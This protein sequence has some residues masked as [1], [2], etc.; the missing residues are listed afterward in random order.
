[1]KT[2]IL[3]AILVSVTALP[4]LAYC[5]PLKEC[6]ICGKT[7]ICKTSEFLGEEIAICG[8]CEKDLNNLASGL[9]DYFG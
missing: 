1:M 9:S 7:K 3:A 4:V 6:D 5:G 2:K 8:D